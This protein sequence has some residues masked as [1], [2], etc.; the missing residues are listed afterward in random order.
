M[1]LLRSLKSTHWVI[2]SSPLLLLVLVF[3]LTA[4]STPARHNLALSTA[5]T[6]TTS[7][8]TPSRHAAR[9]RASTTTTTTTSRDPTTPSERAKTNA[10]ND[11]VSS[12]STTS[13]DAPIASASAETAA[14]GAL[15]GQ[16]E[17][18]FDDA[19]VP[20][21][22]PGTWA[23]AASK[24]LRA[25]LLCQGTA[26]AVTSEFAVGAHETCQLSLSPATP[27]TTLTWQVTPVG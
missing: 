6:A 5:T 9:H 21:E 7:T 23:L 4:S 16:L 13:S 8:T 12:S 1:R 14:N 11:D 17:P 3:T 25:T 15:S 10:R 26:I 22:G 20:F 19:E 27:G 18:T 24:P 2:W